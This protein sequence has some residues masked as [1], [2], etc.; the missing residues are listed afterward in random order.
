M[1][2]CVCL[3]PSFR[4]CL[5]NPGRRPR[6]GTKPRTGVRGACGALILGQRKDAWVSRLGRPRAPFGVPVGSRSLKPRRGEVQGTR[7]PPS[8]AKGPPRCGSSSCA[9]PSRYPLSKRAQS[10][11]PSPHPDAHRSATFAVAPNFP[12]TL[13]E[14]QLWGA[15]R[16]QAWSRPQV[17]HIG[18]PGSL[19]PAAGTPILGPPPGPAPW[20][21]DTCGS[22]QW[23]TGIPMRI[24]GAPVQPRLSDRSRSQPCLETVGI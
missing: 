7:R 13:G 15:G 3:C 24:W 21:A 11:P 1:H 8:R 12:G 23:R 9:P 20:R 5:Q 18:D 4:S 14:S 16:P 19:D 17:W 22:R 6:H 2:L 10:P